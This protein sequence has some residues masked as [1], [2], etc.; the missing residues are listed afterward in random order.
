MF[1]PSSPTIIPPLTSIKTNSDLS[2]IA[3][4]VGWKCGFISYIELHR[5]SVPCQ[6]S[7]VVELELITNNREHWIN[8][9][10]RAAH[11][12]SESVRHLKAKSTT[13]VTLI[14]IRTIV[15][16]HD[17]R[18]GRHKSCTQSYKDIRHVEVF[19]VD[20]LFVSMAAD[21]DLYHYNCCLSQHE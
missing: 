12:T 8:I 15:K 4:V 16:C 7:K 17:D 3:P 11:R 1:I 20:R 5:K 2:K 6:T 10:R 19:I 13:L 9:L 14:L 21:M 18:S